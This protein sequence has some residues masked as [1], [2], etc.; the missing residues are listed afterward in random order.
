MSNV[1]RH[2]TDSSNAPVDIPKYFTGNDH[3]SRPRRRMDVKITAVLGVLDESAGRS[4]NENGV[5]RKERERE[6]PWRVEVGGREEFGLVAGR[7]SGHVGPHRHRSGS[8]RGE[9]SHARSAIWPRRG[10]G[11]PFRRNIDPVAAARVAADEAELRRRVRN[12]PPRLCKPAET[13]R[14]PT[15]VT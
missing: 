6:N 14:G 12:R 13:A 8:R 7:K 15:F 11:R 10:N 3:F 1:T 4:L 5:G 9:G 2:E